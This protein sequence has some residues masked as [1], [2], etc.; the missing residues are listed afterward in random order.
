MREQMMAEEEA[1]TFAARFP[2]YEESVSLF[3]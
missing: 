3:C 2:Y 1:K